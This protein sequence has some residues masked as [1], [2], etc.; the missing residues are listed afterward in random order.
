VYFSCRETVHSEEVVPSTAFD[1]DAAMLQGAELIK[2]RHDPNMLWSTYRRS[3]EIYTAR[4]MTNPNDVIDAFSGIMRTLCNARCVEGLLVPVFDIALLWQPRERLRRRGGFSSW[5]WAGWIGQVHWFDDRFLENF[6]QQGRPQTET[7]KLWVEAHSW[8]VWYSSSGTNCQSR[9][10]RMDGPPRLSGSQAH[11]SGKLLEKHFPGQHIK[12]LPTPSL[13]PD[14]LEN[15]ENYRHQIRYLQF[16]TLS[17]H[18]NIELDALAVIHHSSL[19]PE[20]TGN[21]LRRF[22]LIDQYRRECGWVLLNEDWIEKTT[23]KED[24]LQEFI[25]ISETGGS[26]QISDLREEELGQCWNEYNAMMIV[27]EH[28]IAERVGLGRVMKHSL[29]DS[30]GLNLEWKEIL[31]G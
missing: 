27:W 11:N 22:H 16:W 9:A 7:I 24:K 15:L 23:S 5:S 1:A 10:F 21:G 20:N 3:V 31:L 6:E 25:L 13:L 29:V 8:I 19:E 17:V 26:E 12:S 28:G 2:L 4:K 18:F 30:T 14:R